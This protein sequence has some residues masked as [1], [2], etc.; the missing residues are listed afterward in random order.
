MT[1]S[2]RLIKSLHENFQ[3]TQTYLFLEFTLPFFFS[4]F[5]KDESKIIKNT[6]FSYQVGS[7]SHHIC[8]I[9]T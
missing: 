7:S 1:D 8:H 2:K 3:E 4:N 6:I 9:N 5:K